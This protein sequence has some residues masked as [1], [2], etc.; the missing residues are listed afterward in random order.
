MRVTDAAGAT[1]DPDER[2]TP[3]VDEGLLEALRADLLDAG[4]TVDGVAD[5]LGPVAAAALHREQA[6][7]AR[8]AVSG[9]DDPCGIL[10]SFFTLGQPSSAAALDRALPRLRAV[11]AR[12]LGLAV[13]VTP[14]SAGPADDESVTATATATAPATTTDTDSAAGGGSADEPLVARC[15]LRPYA[16]ERHDWWVASDLGELATGAALRTDHV[17]GIGGASTTLAAWTIRRPVDRALDLGT[18][19]G[20]QALHLVGHARSVVATDVS[21]RARD[22]ALFNLALNRTESA[23]STASTAS[24]GSTDPAPGVDV[25]LGDLLEPV[26]GQRFSLVVS[27]P[28]FVIT[29]RGDD[30]PIYEYRDGGRSGDAVVR[31]LVRGLVDVLEPGGVA[32]LLGNWEVPAGRTWREVWQEWL[33]GVPLD[34]WV[35]QR[36]TQDPAQYAELWSRD[37]GLTADGDTD[38]R[39]Y[40][41]WLR[42]FASRDVESVGFGVIT[43][44]R[45]ESDRA[46]WRDLAEATGPV[47]AA[48]GPVLEAGLR[49][50][51]WLAEH[52]EDEVLA[53]AWSC[54]PDVTEE[55]H[56]VPGASD[57]SVILVRQGGGLGRA[58]RLDTLAAA[59]LG[60]ADGELTAGAAL[61]AIATLVEVP[62]ETVRAAVLP[63]LRGL[64][65]DGILV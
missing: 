2:D 5:R 60:V 41:A 23:A 18:G 39:R 58:V 59:Y 13:T 46:P 33:D 61:D 3:V 63:V 25:V 17:L 15:D 14:G 64:V 24:T 26:A 10:L 8:L 54:A 51:T 45:P 47:A 57:P 48:M 35:V 36:E 11:G 7:P 43:L 38:D 12:R 34:A 65:A 29:P 30:V 22:Y 55:R 16:D 37:A 40:A 52:S 49:A 21:E 20:V 1:R 27:N 19:C 28:P 6:V 42:D 53:V 56:H 62:S 31:S 32:Q 4:F 9:A 44:Q 50:R